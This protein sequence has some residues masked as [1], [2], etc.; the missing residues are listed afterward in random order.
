MVVLSAVLKEV[1]A[2]CLANV[3]ELQDRLQERTGSRPNREYLRRV[4]NTLTESDGGTTFSTAQVSVQVERSEAWVKTAARNIG[5]G[6]VRRTAGRGQLEFTPTDVDLLLAERKDT[7]R[8][9][10]TTK[11]YRALTK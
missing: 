11:K 9:R 10:P 3:N 5:V 2:L 6:R 4:L 7:L 8:G 1:S